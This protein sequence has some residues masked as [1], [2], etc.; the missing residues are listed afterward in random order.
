MQAHSV[1]NA[2]RIGSQTDSASSVELQVRTEE[3][4]TVDVDVFRV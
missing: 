3:I 4:G 1:G 2:Q